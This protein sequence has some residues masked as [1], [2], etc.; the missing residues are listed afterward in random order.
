[1]DPWIPP[2]ISTIVYPGSSWR[3]LTVKFQFEKKKKNISPPTATAEKTASRVLSDPDTESPDTDISR[4]CNIVAMMLWSTRY[5][6]YSR[7]MLIRAIAYKSFMFIR[8]FSL[9]PFFSLSKSLWDIRALQYGYKSFL[10]RV[11]RTP[12]FPSTKHPTD[13]GKIFS[14]K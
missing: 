12:P 14:E 11:L 5:S 8:A 6:Q 13:C 9:A 4:K 7:W 2:L 1:M 3:W 10:C